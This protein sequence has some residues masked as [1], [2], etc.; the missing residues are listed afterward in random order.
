MTQS[1]APAWELDAP[2][3]GE[4]RRP[5]GYL[6]YLTWQSRQI[7]LVPNSDDHETCVRQVAITRGREF[8]RDYYP[9]DPMGVHIARPNAR[10]GQNPWPALRLRADRAVWRDSTALLQSIP[11]GRHRPATVTEIA[12]HVAAGTISRQRLYSLSVLGLCSDRAKVHFWRHERLPLPLS[13]LGD[14]KLVGDLGI[15]L[16]VAEAA[17]SALNAAFRRLAN[18]LA[19]SS[20]D[21]Q[22]SKDASDQ[23]FSILTSHSPFWAQLELHFS[24]FI[25]RLVK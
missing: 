2:T 21:A 5:F 20:D 3:S 13:Y 22:P 24:E 16:Q 8:P 6:D 11:D 9:M 17:G 19:K 1:D 14:D 12:E 7:R 4:T 10:E 23:A 15:G 25:V 18:E